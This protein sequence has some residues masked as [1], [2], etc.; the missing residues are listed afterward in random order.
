MKL[1][2]FDAAQMRRAFVTLHACG[3]EPTTQTMQALVETA[4]V[5]YPDDPA[6]L[7]KA[8]QALATF[9]AGAAIAQPKQETS[10][11]RLRY[12]ALSVLRL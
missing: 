12:W 4:A 2:E 1:P 6:S 5:H 3:I 11:K 7:E 8:A 10:W 9:F